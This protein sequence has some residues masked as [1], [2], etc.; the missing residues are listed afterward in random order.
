MES[1]IIRARA[2]LRIGLAGGG[3]DVS[4]FS[5][6]HGGL[7][8]NATISMYAQCILIPNNHGENIVEFFASDLGKKVFFENP[9]HELPTNDLPLH[10][11]VHN[12]IVRRFEIHI[13]KGFRIDT[14]ADA[15]MG[16]GL[17]TSSTLVVCI[18]EAYNRYFQLGLGKY[19]IAAI[20]YKV[21]RIDLGFKG[22]RQDQ[23]AAVFGGVNSIQCG[24]GSEVIVEPLTLDNSFLNEL[25]SSTVLFFSGISRDS[26]AII[27]HQVRMADQKD[28]EPL[29]AMIALKHDAETMIKAFRMSDLTGYVN[30]LRRSWNN[31]K[32]L[33]GVITNPFLDDIYNAAITA[34]AEAGKISGAGG[35]GFFMFY[36]RPE[37]KQQLL[38]RL[39]KMAG[40]Y[41]GFQF[42][43]KGVESW[44]VP[45]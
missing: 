4:P 32:K 20:A 18:V 17:G 1:K 28:S 43:N 39:T 21:E 9:N 14:Y 26:G 44:V 29:K 38:R 8:L 2:P 45:R 33:S 16:S 25:E 7:V 22:G 42:T 6:R 12:H 36:V 31:K 30:V 19:E 34:G 35:G 13:Q 27:E 41:I 3:T 37:F 23:F 11:G 5:D 40:N 15:P 24:P 10:C